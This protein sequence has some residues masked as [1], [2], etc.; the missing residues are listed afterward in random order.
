[1]SGFFAGESDD[2]EKEKRKM[3][4][5]RE[6]ALAETRSLRINDAIRPKFRFDLCVRVCGIIVSTGA[7]FIASSGKFDLFYG[8]NL[9]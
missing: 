9:L 1:V 6:L 3:G 4:E 5:V 8:R 7:I 2:S